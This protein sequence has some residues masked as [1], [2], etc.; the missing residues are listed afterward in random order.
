MRDL[1]TRREGDAKAPRL[2]SARNDEL[3]P[4][5]ARHVTTTRAEAKTEGG[6]PIGGAQRA[7]E[8]MTAVPLRGVMREHN[9]SRI[10]TGATQRWTPTS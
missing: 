3:A 5:E 6:R 7:L 4:R 1:P 10:T 2:A 9:S 8:R